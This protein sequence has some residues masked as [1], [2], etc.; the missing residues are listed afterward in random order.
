MAQEEKQAQLGPKD[1]IKGLSCKTGQ[2]VKSVECI[3]KP[4]PKLVSLLQ[5]DL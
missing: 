5:E 3:R 2:N 4:R 1:V